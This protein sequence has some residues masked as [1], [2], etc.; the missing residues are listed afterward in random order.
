[1]KTF[2][3]LLLLM[4]ITACSQEPGK[5]GT[6]FSDIPEF[7]PQLIRSV[8]NIDTL[9]YSYLGINSFAAG[10]DVIL[11]VWD[12]AVLVRSGQ[13]LSNVLA[14]TSKGK[15]PGEL[16][17]IGVPSQDSEGNILV[18][19]QFQAKFATFSSD[20]EPV[21][22]T[23]LEPFGEW[24]PYRIFATADPA[25]VFIN[26]PGPMEFNED[27]RQ[28][29]ELIAIFDID[30][31]SYIDSVRT[32]GT[33]RTP[34]GPNISSG[35]GSSFQVPFS[36]KQLIAHKP[37][38]GTML[39]FD[40]ATDRIAEINAELDTLTTILVDLPTEGISQAEMDSIQVADELSDEDIKRMKDRMPESKAP[41]SYM[42]YYNG[43]IW[44]KSNIK[45]Q[46]DIWFVINMEGEIT[47]K[48]LLPP[49]SYL[50]HI[51]DQHLGVRLGDVTFA[52]YEPLPVN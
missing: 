34:V 18:Y 29:E 36:R 20:L 2:L 45:A 39:L 8:Q 4:L 46:H 51:S 12:P 31:G 44:L 19:D 48:V 3:P 16:Q 30:S 21:R 25:K 9:Y 41:A 32:Y 13:D 37:E 50:T 38:S 43:Q 11:P 24:R 28:R 5:S 7:E 6:D 52:L 23:I 27:M 49:S 17:D 33:T 35:Y 40:N 42:K 15:G 1:M 47:Q 22:E 14:K 26:M 10:D